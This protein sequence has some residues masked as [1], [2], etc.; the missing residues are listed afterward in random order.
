L[1]IASIAYGALLGVFLLGLLTKRATESGAI[2]GMICGFA[3]EV[4]VW[5]FSLPDFVLDAYARIAGHAPAG[6]KLAWTWYVLVGTFVTFAVGYGASV[7]LRPK[8]VAISE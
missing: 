6:T 7:L 4:Y 1:S 3:I 5:R 2:I 8:R